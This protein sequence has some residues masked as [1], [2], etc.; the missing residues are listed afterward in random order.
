MNKYK[1]NI[2]VNRSNKHYGFIEGYI[3]DVYWY[4]MV[5]DHDVKN[6]I[7]PVTLESGYGKITKCVSTKTIHL[8]KAILTYHR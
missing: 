1:Y 6:A 3:G 2:C 8:L 7:D 5:H 4:A